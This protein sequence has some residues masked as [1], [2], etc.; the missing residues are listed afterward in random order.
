MVADT[1]MGLTV[2]PPPQRAMPALVSQGHLQQSH[3]RVQA[4]IPPRSQLAG[5]GERARPCRGRPWPISPGCLF[6]L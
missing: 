3:F 2:V 1:P 5:E 6:S 4:A